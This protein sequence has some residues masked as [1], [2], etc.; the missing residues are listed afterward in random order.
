MIRAAFCGS[1]I[2]ERHSLRRFAARVNRSHRRTCTRVC[3]GVRYDGP[4]T[5]KHHDDRCPYASSDDRGL[6]HGNHDMSAFDR[7]PAAVL[8]LKRNATADEPEALLIVLDFLMGS[9]IDDIAAARRAASRDVVED[10]LRAVMLEY[11]F[12]AWKGPEP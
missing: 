7:N 3:T 6:R 9:S 12:T 10:A 4:C 1:S 11:G 2:F 5:D 8:H